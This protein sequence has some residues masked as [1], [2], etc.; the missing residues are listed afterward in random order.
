MSKKKQREFLALYDPV[1]ERFERFCRARVYG[2]MEYSDLMNDTLLVA[3]SKFD[4]IKNKTSLLSY[5]C[6]VSIRLLANS[7]RKLKPNLGLDSKEMVTVD[8]NANTD[9]DVKVALLYEAMS[10]LPEIQR[11]CLILFEI[12]GFSIK[13]IMEIQKSSESAIK[14]RLRRGRQRLMEILTFESENKRGRVNNE[15]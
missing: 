8:S 12:T 7:N 13:E 14:Q 6:G 3:Y 9:K 4:S 5:L 11:E 1:H 10:Y 15:T 2:D